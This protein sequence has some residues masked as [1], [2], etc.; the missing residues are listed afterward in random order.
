VRTAVCVNGEEIEV[1][2]IIE[3]DVRLVREL[4]CDVMDFCRESVWKPR[5]DVP[6]GPRVCELEEELAEADGER[7]RM[8]RQRTCSS[9]RNESLNDV[10][11]DLVEGRW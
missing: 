3:G 4:L 5:I 11:V 1:N 10:V 8:Y 2:E 7:V 6:E 9:A